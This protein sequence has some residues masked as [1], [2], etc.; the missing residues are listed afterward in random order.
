MT[1]SYFGTVILFDY[2]QFLF[3]LKFSSSDPQCE[4]RDVILFESLHFRLYTK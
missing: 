1:L 3:V 2:L 4:L